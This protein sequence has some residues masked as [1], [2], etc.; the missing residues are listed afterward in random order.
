M[1]SK[2]QAKM[3]EIHTNDGVVT[4]DKV[5]MS[6]ESIPIEMWGNSTSYN[7]EKAIEYL[8]SVGGGSVRVPANEKY[9]L[10]V[11]RVMWGRYRSLPTPDMVVRYEY[12]DWRPP[13]NIVEGG[14]TTGEYRPY[15]TQPW[16]VGD[17][18][19]NSDMGNSDDKVVDWYCTLSGTEESPA[20]QW[21][22]IN[23]DVPA[24]QGRFH[25]DSSTETL[26]FV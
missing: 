2:I 13:N 11:I 22:Y 25:Y 6:S 16:Q 18:I 1:L 19:H 23:A 21:R 4:L 7:I 3:I 10:L 5:L 17:I 14:I 26:T 12:T 9:N 20:G 24:G 15:S 8:K